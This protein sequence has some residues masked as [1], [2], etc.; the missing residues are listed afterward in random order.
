MKFL[1]DADFLVALAKSDD[2]NHERATQKAETTKGADIFITPF[3]IPETVTVVS[4]KASQTAAKKLLKELRSKNF[5]EIS[6]DEDIMRFA[7]ELFATQGA[8]GTS[9][10]DC[11]NVVVVKNYKLDGILSFDAF[12]KKQGIALG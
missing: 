11:L 4:Y 10:I 9:W 8:K 5:I 7:D 3:T 1:A 12:Y 6:L 2:A